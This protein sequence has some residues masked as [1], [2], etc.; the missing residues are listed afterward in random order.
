MIMKRTITIAHAGSYAKDHDHDFFG[1]VTATS[2]FHRSEAL[3]GIIKD[4][5]YPF[6]IAN[7]HGH[8]EEQVRSDIEDWLKF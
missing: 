6:E 1:H 3:M 8:I 7:S 2:P 5:L 4:Q